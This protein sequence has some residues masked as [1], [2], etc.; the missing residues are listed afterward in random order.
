MT[1]DTHPLAEGFAHADDAQWRLLAE[2]AL[3]GADLERIARRTLDGVTR[4]PLFTRAHLEEVSDPG[5][6]GAAP[7]VRGL[8]AVR[9]PYLPWAIRQPVDHPDPKQANAVIL[10]E[11][12]G[13]ASEISLRLDPAGEAG[14]A[15]RTLDELKTALDG[16]MLDL[17]PVHLAPSGAGQQYA[18]MMGALLEESGLGPETIRGGFGLS[19]I[20][21]DAGRLAETA[22][23]CHDHFPGVRA[24]S[25]AATAPHEAGGSEAQEIA[26]VCAAGAAAMRA[27]ID[28]G[29][30]PD[31]A[32]GAI[33]VSM[34][35]DADIHLTI[36]KIRAARRAWARVA[37]SFGVSPQQRGMR[38]LAVTSRRMLTARD[39][40]TNLIRNTCAAFGAA[41]GGADAITVRPFTDVIGAPTPF[42][43]RLARNLQVMLAEESHLGKTADPAGGGYLHETIGQR[44]ADK[45][46]AVF[47]EIEGEGG[48][49]RSLKS[50]W[51][52]AGIEQ[53]AQLRRNAYATG[54]ESLI[55]VST[56]PELDAKTVEADTR[57]YN[58]PKL[59][60]PVAEPAPVTEAIA[61]FRQGRK[62]GEPGKS[63]TDWAPLPRIRFAEPFEAL[64]DGAD[65]YASKTGARPKAFLATL[66]SLAEFNARTSF[67]KNR[68]AV[69]GIEAIEPEVHESVDACAQAFRASGTPLAVIC[70]TDALYKSH[71]RDL[72]EKLKAAGAK[73]VWLA[74]RPMGIDGIGRSIH[75]RSDAVED[76]ASA[77]QILGVA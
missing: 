25:I 69:G 41:A 15:I 26:Y 73:E 33:E 20:E 14:V 46:W 74:G 66:G 29:L 3:K 77:H 28:H 30:S 57:R 27:F 9:D 52:Q 6:P 49:S 61:G 42:A 34:A 50:G 31:E 38:L 63:G 72:T 64:R 23:Y 70:G 71:A 60:A 5:A 32:A 43:R 24:V 13:G 4:G 55:G 7:F 47:Q 62:I 65:D 48:L 45:G 12:N 44:L 2:K 18:A 37:E 51:L 21:Q 10:Q 67:A 8:D 17:A 11:L 54:K 35:A 16:V 19:A 68:L 58:P 22:R 76:L 36:A 1:D 75:M 39:P 40:W 53:V 59:D 56:Y